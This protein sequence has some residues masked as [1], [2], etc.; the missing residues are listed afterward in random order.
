MSVY[1]LIL[2]S[3]C[4]SQFLDFVSNS[5]HLFGIFPWIL[6]RLSTTAGGFFS[7]SF[8][9][10]FFLLN[11]FFWSVS[12]TSPIILSHL[13]WSL[14]FHPNPNRRQGTASEVVANITNLET[15]ISQLSSATNA[16]NLAAYAAEAQEAN[17]WTQT[18]GENILHYEQFRSW[19]SSLSN[20][21]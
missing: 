6:N 11:S 17:N 1:F 9:P 2:Y 3:L 8:P 15:I 5:F 4:T 19:V 12:L 7:F 18:T 14:N 21:I 16:P 13:L 10:F 20:Q